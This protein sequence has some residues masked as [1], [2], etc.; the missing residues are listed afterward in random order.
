M[1]NCKITS[2]T[3]QE[4]VVDRTAGKPECQYGE[5]S[6]DLIKSF[7]EWQLKI[8]TFDFVLMS[9]SK[10]RPILSTLKKP[11]AN[12]FRLISNAEEA[13]KTLA[14]LQDTA[15]RGFELVM[16]SSS[17]I[18]DI[19]GFWKQKGYRVEGSSPLGSGREHDLFSAAWNKDSLERMIYVAAR[20]RA[21]SLCVFAHDADPLYL[22]TQDGID[23]VAA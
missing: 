17:S 4:L 19:E 7:Y 1:E 8:G 10:D 22:L 18:A 13:V 21:K 2:W 5:S 12:L 9:G 14:D 3:V 11:E 23:T 15:N 6:L 16:A 20:M